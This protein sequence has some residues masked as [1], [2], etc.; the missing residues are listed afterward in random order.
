MTAESRLEE[1][2]NKFKNELSTKLDANQEKNEAVT[3]QR[4]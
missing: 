3:K 4:Y 2:T 1:K